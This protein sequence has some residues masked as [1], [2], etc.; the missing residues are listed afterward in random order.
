MFRSFV[1]GSGDA[2]PDC[3]RIEIVVQIV[4][5][6]P[7]REIL[8]TLPPNRFVISN[9]VELVFL[10]LL[11]SGMNFAA[12]LRCLLLCFNIRCGG[13]WIASNG[14]VVASVLLHVVSDVDNI[15]RFR[16]EAG[17]EQ[18]HVACVGSFSTPIRTLGLAGLSGR[19]PHYSDR[20]EHLIA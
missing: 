14:K 2:Y 15:L 5:R 8:F 12:P 3:L 4:M 20:S 6:D 7:S 13:K 9:N 17:F 16:T 10:V 19:H 11:S 1:A 18:Q